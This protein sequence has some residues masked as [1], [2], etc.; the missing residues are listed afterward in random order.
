V[1]RPKACGACPHARRRP[2]CDH[3]PS[4]YLRE[5]AD[6]ASQP[7]APIADVDSVREQTVG[8]RY[9]TLRRAVGG[10]IAAVL[11]IGT[12]VQQVSDWP[13]PLALVL[14]PVGSM[15]VTRSFSSSLLRIIAAGLLSFVAFVGGSA[16]YDSLSEAE[17]VA[18]H[19]SLVPAPS[20]A[21]AP[22]V[23]DLGATASKTIIKDGVAWSLTDDR[24]L[25][26]VDLTNH[27][28]MP[29]IPVDPASRDLL[30]CGSHL[31]LLT[32][33]GTALVLRASDG[34]VL[35]KYHFDGQADAATCSA[36]WLW[37]VHGHVLVRLAIPAL[38]EEPVET[39]DLHQ[40]IDVLFYWH[41]LLWALD[42]QAGALIGYDPVFEN[43]QAQA[44]LAPGASALLGLDRKLAAVHTGI[45]CVR[46]IDLAAQQEAGRGVPLT[47]NPFAAT[48]DGHS[49]AIADHSTSAITLI[50]EGNVR[51]Y[52]LPFGNRRINGLAMD[53][54]WVILNDESQNS[55]L[56][57]RRSDLTALDQETTPRLPACR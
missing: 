9:A 53:G 10:G 26:R 20:R 55:L 50:V 30:L 56:I 32:R 38:G 24:R 49:A 43:A 51:T 5:G 44:S 19:G 21:P 6:G 42:K 25:T 18:G 1:P 54:R 23:V 8:G 27:V 46:R 40:E 37:L 15:L 33:S 41:S 11:A 29:P 28:A 17:H 39:R 34:R 13:K 14:V 4:C 45:S 2:S 47:P 12:A 31:L 48:S 52:R 35:R 16:I 57:F 22:W 36:S 3:V 7:E